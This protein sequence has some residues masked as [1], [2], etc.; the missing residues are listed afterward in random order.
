[1]SVNDPNKPMDEVMLAMDVVDTLR[2]NSRVV[3]RELNVEMREAELLA[4]LKELYGTQ[5]I[6]VSDDIL[7]EGVIALRE[8]RFTYKPTPPSF[9]RS[10]AK[11]YIKRHKWG[12]PLLFFGAFLLIVLILN[13]FGS[14]MPAGY[15]A[16]AQ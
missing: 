1:M 12:K 16:G 5:G 9:S 10:L 14:P 2:R 3:E 11:F 6:E 4:R 15:V 7:R 8:D 13:L